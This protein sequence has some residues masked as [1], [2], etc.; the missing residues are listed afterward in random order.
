MADVGG[1]EATH[2]K[3]RTPSIQQLMTTNLTLSYLYFISVRVYHGG[4]SR[5]FPR[6]AIFHLKPKVNKE[7]KYQTKYFSRIYTSKRVSDWRILRQQFA[8]S[9][10]ILVNFA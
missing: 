7:Q 8:T 10:R 6:F 9:T 4:T 1:V 5:C 3:F 2:L